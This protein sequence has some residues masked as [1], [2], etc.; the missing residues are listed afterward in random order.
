MTA[1]E[2]AKNLTFIYFLKSDLLDQI[3]PLEVSQDVL[4]DICKSYVSV[5]DHFLKAASS[6]VEKPKPNVRVID[7]PPGW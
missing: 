5:Y 2:I 3:N 1:D 4:K 6:I 7:K